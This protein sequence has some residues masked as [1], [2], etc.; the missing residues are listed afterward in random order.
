MYTFPTLNRRVTARHGEMLYNIH[1]SY[2]GRSLGHYGEYCE[3]EISLLR[4]IL[5]PGDVVVEVG[6][7]IGPHTLFFARAAGPTGE[8]LA[9]EPQRMVHQLLC[10][11]MA[12]NSVTN[13]RTFHAA[14]SETEGW[15]PVP[16]VDYGRENNFGG[17]G[18]DRG[19]PGEEVQVHKLD[20]FKFPRLKLIKIDVEGME[21]KVL[22]GA[23]ATLERHRPFL[24]VENDRQEKSVSLI[25]TL[26]EM[27]YRLF[28]HRRFL[29]NPDNFFKNPENVFGNIIS[30]NMLGLPPGVDVVIEG[31]LPVEEGALPWS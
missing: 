1:D 9:F 15:L 5:G 25:S 28:W 26:H 22:R 13:V 31:L 20:S 3:G 27:R 6:A 16:R 19:L 14:L 7:N 10:A 4:Q 12:L 2:V 23:R 8:V 18:L 21:E 17:M 30:T 29:F 11:N 24:Y